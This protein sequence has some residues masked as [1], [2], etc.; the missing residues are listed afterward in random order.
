MKKKEKEKIGQSGMAAIIL[1]IV[2]VTM[3]TITTSTIIT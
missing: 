1:T 3:M 2:V